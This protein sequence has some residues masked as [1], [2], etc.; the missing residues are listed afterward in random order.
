MGSEAKELSVLFVDDAEMAELNE[1][2]RSRSGPTNVLS[3]PMGGDPL[4]PETVMLGDVVISVDTARREARAAG[5]NL[6]EAVDRLLVHGLLH[7]LGYD[8][9]R[10]EAEASA[11]EREERSVLA[12]MREEA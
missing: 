2:Y 10:G 9:E 1:R 4:E 8:H 6:E 5:E 3:F 11:M 7:L 12:R